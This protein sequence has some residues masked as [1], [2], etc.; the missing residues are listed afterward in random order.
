[1][2]ISQLTI[3]LFVMCDLT[4]ALTNLF[5]SI[6]SAYVSVRNDMFCFFDDNFAISCYAV[7]C[8]FWGWDG[9]GGSGVSEITV[10]L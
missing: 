7:F 6:M 2:D 10:L 9:G 4:M 3:N 8:L 5:V 1:M